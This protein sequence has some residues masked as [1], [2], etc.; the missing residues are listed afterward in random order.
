MA[1]IKDFDGL[2]RLDGKIAVLSGG[3]YTTCSHLSLG[4]EH[5]CSFITTTTSSCACS[6]KQNY[7]PSDMHQLLTFLQVPAALVYTSPAPSSSPAA[8]K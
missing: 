8:P 1:E 4:P 7:Q 2:F 6:S 5:Q 3:T